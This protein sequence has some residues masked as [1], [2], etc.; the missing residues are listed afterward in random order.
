MLVVNISIIIA[1]HHY[2]SS[3]KIVS[4]KYQAINRLWDL[5]WHD[6]FSFIF[7]LNK[8]LFIYS[9]ETQAEE[10]PA[11]SRLHAGQSH[12]V[13]LNPRTPGSRPGPKAQLS[14]P[15]VPSFHLLSSQI[16]SSLTVW[17]SWKQSCLLCL[18]LL[19]FFGVLQSFLNLMYLQI[20]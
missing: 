14:H 10:K 7:F 20:I 15:G 11:P 4:P 3:Y 1:T 12:D 19:L 8:I 18:H 17:D 9:W 16:L 5:K 2:S 13:G 6:Y